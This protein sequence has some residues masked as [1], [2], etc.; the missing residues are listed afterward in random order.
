M[1]L[2]EGE[3]LREPPEALALA[4][5]QGGGDRDGACRWIGSAHAKGITHR[6]LKPE[7]IFLTADGQVKILDFGIAR[8]KPTLAGQTISLGTTFQERLRQAR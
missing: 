4:L 8:V 2:L 6:D 7:N 5:A 1:E 3:T